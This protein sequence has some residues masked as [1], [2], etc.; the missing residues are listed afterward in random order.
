MI[1]GFTGSRP[2]KLGGFTLPNSIYN[3]VCQETEKLLLQLKP[4]KCIS[5][6]A[7][8]YDSYAANICIKLKIPYIA[9]IPF[10]NQD[11]IWS[12]EQKKIYNFLLRK[13]SEQV[14]VSEGEYAPC[15]MQI[16]NEYIVDNS[17]V[18]I[19][20]YDGTSGGTHNCVT[21]AKK[22]AKQIFFINTNHL[23]P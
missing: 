9:A 7:L 5:G 6:M 4:D 10:K 13:S 16:R 19:A 17:D 2:Q 8:G 1:I 23:T 21:Y 22:Q 14:T 18:I 3:Y 12:D 11:S 15:K 20:C